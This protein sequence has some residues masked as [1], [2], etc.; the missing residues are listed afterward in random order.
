M[1]NILFVIFCFCFFVIRA[2]NVR[3]CCGN[4]IVSIAE[5]CCGDGDNS[6]AHTYDKNKVCC[7]N[8]YVDKDKSLCCQNEV[9]EFKV[10]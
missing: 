3:Q 4:K 5:Q 9:K 7:G 1:I 6:T 2:G 10:I 8:T